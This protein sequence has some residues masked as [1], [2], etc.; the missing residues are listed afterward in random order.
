MRN[1]KDIWFDYYT[2]ALDDCLDLGLLDEEAE[3]EACSVA[4]DKTQDYFEGL[5]DYLYE[6]Q[7]DRAMEREY[8]L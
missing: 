4:N 2:E 8:A 7:R 6:Q 1:H 3:E 5:G